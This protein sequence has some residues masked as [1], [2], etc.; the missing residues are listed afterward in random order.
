[1]HVDF[2]LDWLL[3]I[4]HAWMNQL[5]SFNLRFARYLMI[6]SNIL[7]DTTRF[8][9]YPIHFHYDYSCFY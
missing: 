8:C 4:P 7:L 2:V 1:M 3:D 5:I 9:V 6:I